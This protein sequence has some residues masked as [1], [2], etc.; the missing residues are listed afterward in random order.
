ME[1]I[2]TREVN[3]TTRVRGADEPDYFE[4]DIGQTENIGTDSR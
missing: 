4:G 1:N 3:G 2:V